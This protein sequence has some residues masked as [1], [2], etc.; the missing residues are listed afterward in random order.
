MQT[1]GR[2]SLGGAK[3]KARFQTLSFV[4]IL[5]HAAQ[6]KHP[7][8][9]PRLHAAFIDFKHAYDTIPREALWTYLQCICMPTCLLNIIDSMQMTNTFWLMAASKPV[10]AHILELSKAARFLPCFS[11]YINDV[12]CLAENVQGAITGTSD[13]RVVHTVHGMLYADDLCLTSN[14]ADQLQ[15]MLDRLHVYAQ[16]KGLVINVV[17]SEI[18]HFYSRSDASFRCILG[19]KQTTPNC[20]AFRFYNALLRSNSTTLRKVLQADVEMS[21]KHKLRNIAR[22]CLHAHT[23]RVETSLWQEHTSECDRCDQGGLQDKKQTVLFL[24]ESGAFYY[25]QASPEDVSH[26]QKQSGVAVAGAECYL[27][28]PRPPLLL[29]GNRELI[30]V[31]L[32]IGIISVSSGRLEVGL[33]WSGKQRGMVYSGRDLFIGRSGSAG[34][35]GLRRCR[36][37]VAAMKQGTPISLQDFTDDLRHRLRGAWR[38]VEGGVD[39]WTTNNKLTT[40]QASFALTFDQNVHKPI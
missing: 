16:R 12:E 25:T 9:S 28:P 21:S 6:V 18:V 36:S 29:E 7:N 20:A 1:L 15:L 35:Q 2:W 4:S 27:L 23:L 33:C 11:L 40:Y 17:E 5:A 10:C 39:P 26:F 38:A 31:T 3:E 19:L 37:F 8:A 22:F 14:Q 34:S 13:V 32:L 30:L 24:D